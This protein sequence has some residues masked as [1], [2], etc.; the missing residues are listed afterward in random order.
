MM[1]I[2]QTIRQS[3]LEAELLSKGYSLIDIYGHPKKFVGLKSF[4]KRCAVS[5]LK[6]AF[7][8]VFLYSTFTGLIMLDSA[9]NNGSVNVHDIPVLSTV[10]N[11]YDSY[12]AEKAMSE[13]TADDTENNVTNDFMGTMM[14]DA[15]SKF[16]GFLE[17]ADDAVFDVQ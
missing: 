15:T 7:F 6:V 9:V 11:Y 5:V 2:D 3:R 12:V 1:T 14:N 13:E 8:S 4:L 17:M 16:D 10:S